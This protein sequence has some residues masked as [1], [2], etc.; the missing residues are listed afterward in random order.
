MSPEQVVQRQLDAYNAKNLDAFMACYAD[1][2]RLFRLAEALPMIAGKAA[3]ATFYA[4]HRF[5]RPQ[6]HARLMSRMVLGNKVID[7]ELVAGLSEASDE[8]VHAAV[9]FQ[10]DQSL[11]K[12]VWILDAS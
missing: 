11:I 9:V 7:H 1:D 10:V 8:P 3:L 4:E 5:N 2:V 12:N 6:L